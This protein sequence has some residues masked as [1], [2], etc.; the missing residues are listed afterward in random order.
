MLS[1]FAPAALNPAWSSYK[2]PF[3]GA[4]KRD[5]GFQVILKVGPADSPAPVLGGP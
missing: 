3:Y 5:F 2:E 4:T 1:W